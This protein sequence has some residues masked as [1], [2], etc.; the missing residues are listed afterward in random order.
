VTDF[1]FLQIKNDTTD[2]AIIII[3]IIITPLAMALLSQCDELYTGV[4]QI[5]IC[6]DPMVDAICGLLESLKLARLLVGQLLLPVFILCICK[7]M[8][9][10]N[11]NSIILFRRCLPNVL[12]VSDT[13][14]LS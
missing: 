11:D 4:R 2:L 9:F 12:L 7:I 8:S 14:G 13:P 1:L 10:I 3:I 6:G 5:T